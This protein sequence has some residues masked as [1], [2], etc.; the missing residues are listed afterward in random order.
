MNHMPTTAL[1]S[2][3]NL[4]M[5]FDLFLFGRLSRDASVRKCKFSI[6]TSSCGPQHRYQVS[7]HCIDCLI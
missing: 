1:K 7:G 5:L 4:P 2:Y 3:D 6:H